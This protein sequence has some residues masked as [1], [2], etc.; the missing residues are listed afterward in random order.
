[1]SVVSPSIV[2]VME[3]AFTTL[4]SFLLFFVG[5]H[6][7]I[8]EKKGNY[9]RAIIF[10]IVSLPCCILTVAMTLSSGE[11]YA[12]AFKWLFAFMA[13]FNILFLIFNGFQMY[14]IHE[15]EKPDRNKRWSR[16]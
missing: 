4:F 1:M 12:L 9:A 5:L 2:Y 11:A 15:S 10:H 13:I 8:F 14:N 3:L 7:G 6:D 16:D